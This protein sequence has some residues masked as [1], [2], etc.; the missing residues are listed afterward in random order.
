MTTETGERGVGE[1]T[2]TEAYNT[3][4]NQINAYKIANF[5][6]KMLKPQPSK[7][8]SKMNMT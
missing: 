7:S 3:V 2:Q 8:R 1:I 5:R 4:M 6:F